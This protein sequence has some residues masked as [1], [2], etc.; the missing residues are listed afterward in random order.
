[1]MTNEPFLSNLGV[2]VEQQIRT[3]KGTSMPLAFNP[4]NTG[5]WAYAVD[6]LSPTPGQPYQ[7]WSFAI[8]NYLDLCEK[9]QRFPFQ[10]IH[11]GNN[12]KITAFLKERRAAFVKFVNQVDLFETLTF[13]STHHKVTATDRGFILEVYAQAF[14]NDP[15]FLE[16]LTHSPMPHFSPRSDKGEWRRPLMDGLSVFVRNEQFDLKTRWQIGYDIS[17]PLYPDLPN[18][19]TPSKSE[20][21]K[22]ILDVF[23]MPILRTMRP[24]R[25]MHRLI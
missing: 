20:I 16:W 22:F 12:D 1:M 9:R 3:P 24:I 11:E 15:S 17:C 6:M 7:D 8:K 18:N 25:A 5:I 21:E 2:P 14:L 23:W 19:G 4:N 10:D 13:K